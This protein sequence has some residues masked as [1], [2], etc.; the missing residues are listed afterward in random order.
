MTIAGADPVTVI[1][2][3]GL[4]V[5]AQ[6]FSRQNDSIGRSDDLFPVSATDIHTAVEC[7][8]TVE[9]IDA[10]TEAARYLAFDGPEVRGGVGFNPVGSRGVTGQAHGQTNHGG[11][12]QG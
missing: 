10:L 7:P 3:D 5:S 6:S 4:A 11:T 8:F 1:N 2:H 12:G 9:W